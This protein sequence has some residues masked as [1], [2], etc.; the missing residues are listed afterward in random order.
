L[1]RREGASP[2]SGHP[3]LLRK[4]EERSPYLKNRNVRAGS[5]CSP[6]KSCAQR[7]SRDV[8]W[9]SLRPKFQVSGSQREGGL[10]KGVLKK[11]RGNLTYYHR[12][13]GGGGVAVPSS[14]RQEGQ[15]TWNT[16]GYYLRLLD[17]NLAGRRKKEARRT[18]GA[19]G[20]RLYRKKMSRRAK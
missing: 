18:E 9:R 11:E 3:K 1:T 19:K 4:E 12:P 13:S 15:E 14:F 8:G 17:V 2:A 16:E 6:R 10:K 5:C 7:K 20:A